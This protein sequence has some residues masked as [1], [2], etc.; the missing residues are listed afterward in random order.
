MIQVLT[1]FEV[2]DF[3]KWQA[4]FKVG[5]SMRMAAGSKASHVLQDADNPKIVS[6]ITEWTDL[7]SAKKFSRSAELRQSQQDAG[8]HSQPQAYVLEVI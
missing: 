5:E 2:A 8:V 4:V 1:R 6:V 7:E 3:A